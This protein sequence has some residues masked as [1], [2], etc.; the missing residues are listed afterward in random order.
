MAALIA[1]C[2]RDAEHALEDIARGAGGEAFKNSNDLSGKLQKALDDNRVYYT[3][4]FY[5]PSDKPEAAFRQIA[6]RVKNHPDY[7]V[8]AQKGYL[9]L[10]PAEA[11]TAKTPQQKMIQAL[12]APLPPNEVGVAATA[13]FLERDDDKA[14]VSLKVFID[15]SSLDYRQ[16]D[17]RQSL[18]LEL[19]GVVLDLKGNTIEKF[20]DKIEASLFPERV[21]QAKLNGYRYTR[22]LRLK[23]GIYQVRVAVREPNS[24]RIGAASVWV[25]TPD[26]RKGNLLMSSV[27]LSER[28]ADREKAQTKQAEFFHPRM[29]RGITAYKSGDFL[30]YYFELYNST[31]KD[32]R[33]SDLTMQTEIAQDERS[34]YRSQ[35]QPIASRVI[36]DNKN[37]PGVSGQIPMLLSPGL[38]ELRITI[39]GSDQKQNLE[40]RILFRV[41]S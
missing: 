41:D 38:Y 31:E 29:T 12:A 28:P 2:R 14:Q 16:Q 34:I 26:L 18:A 3:L 1:E 17:R 23:P 5:P 7:N 10:T 40:Q 21:Q 36:E 15:G 33:L 27:I 25:E 13:D 11:R 24:E 35:W 22:R 20:G 30:V 4:A 37:S 39:K 32:R 9:P 19:A 8:R 6:V